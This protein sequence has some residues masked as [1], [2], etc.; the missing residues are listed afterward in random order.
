MLVTP[1]LCIQCPLLLI[2]DWERSR[3]KTLDYTLL[4]KTFY[5]YLGS[6][7]ELYNIL[8]NGFTSYFNLYFY[9]AQIEDIRLLQ[10]IAP[11]VSGEHRAGQTQ[12]L[13]PL[14]MHTFTTV[15]VH[16]FVSCVFFSAFFFLACI[17]FIK[18]NDVITRYHHFCDKMV[19]FGKKN[20]YKNHKI[21]KQ[22]CIC[23]RFTII[24]L[25]LTLWK[26]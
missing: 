8:I 21:L 20:I 16:F 1:L 2:M 17:A 25:D 13:C 12:Y 10:K 9:I 6:A 7:L 5:R 11:C 23:N 22:I 24:Q 4:V 26:S 14:F 3:I 19:S 15:L 18:A